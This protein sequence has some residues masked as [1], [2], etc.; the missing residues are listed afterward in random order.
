MQVRSPR[1]GIQASNILGVLRL[2]LFRGARSASLRMT[3]GNVYSGTEY[4]CQW[5]KTSGLIGFD[6]DFAVDVFQV[7]PGDFGV[8]GEDGQ[9][10]LRQGFFVILLAV[11]DCFQREK[12]VSHD[13]GDIEVPGCGN[14]I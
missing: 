8:E 2:A 3:E 4:F 7:S 12:I 9:P 10:I 5:Q 1:D 11:L 14:Q 13:P 6:C